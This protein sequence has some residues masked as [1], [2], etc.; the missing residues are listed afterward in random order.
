MD[1]PL[2]KREKFAVSLREQ[3]R[4]GILAQKRSDFYFK[5]YKQVDSENPLLAWRREDALIN[6]IKAE[7]TYDK[8]LGE[9]LATCYREITNLLKNDHQLT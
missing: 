8:S 5:T 1:D 9:R 6:R 2:G 7:F 4:K 3:K